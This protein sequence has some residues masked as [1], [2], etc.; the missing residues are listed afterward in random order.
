MPST[1]DPF[2]AWLAAIM[3]VLRHVGSSHLQSADSLHII[4]SPK[5]RWSKNPARSRGGPL[6]ASVEA[7]R[8]TFPRDSCLLLHENH[9]T[10]NLSHALG[11]VSAGVVSGSGALPVGEPLFF[12]WKGLQV[13]RREGTGQRESKAQPAQA[14]TSTTKA[15]NQPLST[16]H[17]R[18]PSCR[19][20]PQA[21][22]AQCSHGTSPC[23]RGPVTL[24]WRR[25]AG[26]H[27]PTYRYGLS[28]HT[29]EPGETP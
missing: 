12:L 23:F 22:H 28:S 18:P 1:Y 24:E 20:E 17:A 14:S 8:G 5:W 11:C 19:L 15:Q 10:I 25:M 4:G 2:A 6:Y 21:A 3:V 26:S 9:A 16:S 7:S 13:R 29:A 27:A